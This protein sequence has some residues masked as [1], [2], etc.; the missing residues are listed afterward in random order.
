M[1]CKVKHAVLN[2]DFIIIRL[3]CDAVM[4]ILRAIPESVIA[5]ADITDDGVALDFDGAVERMVCVVSRPMMGIDKQS[6][7]TIIGLYERNSHERGIET[8]ITLKT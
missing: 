3:R 8:R 5:V 1:Q 2:P 6:A 7:P 4:H